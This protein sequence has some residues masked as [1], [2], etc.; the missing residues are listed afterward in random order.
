MILCSCSVLPNV[1]CFCNIFGFLDPSGLQFSF[2][3]NGGPPRYSLMQYIRNSTSGLLEWKEIG[4]V[5]SK[6]RRSFTTVPNLISISTINI[7]KYVNFFLEYC[8]LK[9]V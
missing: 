4:D 2:Y 3:E 8:T 5:E 7:I 6:H 9:L 1:K